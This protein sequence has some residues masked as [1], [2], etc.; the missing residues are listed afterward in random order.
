MNEHTIEQLIENLWEIIDEAKAV[1]LTAD[2]C[3][4]DRDKALDILD[5]IKAAFPNEI[6]MSKEI[7][8][9]RNNYIESGKRE[10]EAIKKQAE[11]YAKRCVNEN[12]ITAEAR[13][14]ANDMV[15]AAEKNSKE[16]MRAAS[17]YCDDAMKR[18]EEAIAKA[19]EELRTSRAQFIKA[20]RERK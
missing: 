19:L 6:K 4:I 16:L 20:A 11:E 7:V 15:L 10:A 12:D 1:P 8:E 17:E 5:E 18:T 14:K 2:K 13:K 9:K 3:I